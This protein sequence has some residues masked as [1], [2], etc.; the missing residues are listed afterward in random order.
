MESMS[1]PV[2]VEAARGLPSLYQFSVDFSS[3]HAL[4][5]Q[6]L[7]QNL[8]EQILSLP[9]PSTV[10][11]DTRNEDSDAHD[12]DNRLDDVSPSESPNA[13]DPPESSEIE[14]RQ[15][16]SEDSAV[17]HDDDQAIT[18]D[19]LQAAELPAQPANVALPTTQDE[20]PRERGISD[21][22]FEQHADES[23]QR[24]RLAFAANGETSEEQLTNA[25][26]ADQDAELLAASPLVDGN[27]EKQLT[28]AQQELPTNP[29]L[30]VEQHEAPLAQDTPNG[31]P[32]LDAGQVAIESTDLA[33]EQSSGR[34]T[35]ALSSEQ[36]LSA[37]D[38]Q[39]QSDEQAVPNK[40]PR[41]QRGQRREKWYESEAGA[42]AQTVAL[43]EHS[44]QDSALEVTPQSTSNLVREASQQ[45][46]IAEIPQPAAPVI[47]PA[48]GVT[49]TTID[50]T[51]SIPVGVSGST[52]GDAGGV[53]GQTSVQTDDGLPASAPS[54]ESMN[55][56][57]RNSRSDAQSTST[58]SQRTADLTQAERVRLV[59]RVSRS[60]ARL[61]PTGGSINLKLHPP[62]LGSLNVQ[63]RLEG[64]TMTAKLTTESVAAR[65]VI[66]ESLPVLR[67][68]LAEQGFEISQFQVDVAENHADAGN[69][70]GNQLNQSGDGAGQSYRQAV[71]QRRLASQQRQ[72]QASP[73]AVSALPARELGWQS[74]AGIDLHA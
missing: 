21:A 60:F 41:V 70:S 57:N 5:G 31:E 62:Q 59:Q 18:A 24:E 30:P 4:N 67:G 56:A 7:N 37:A 3:P 34:D 72:R 68:R 20:Q 71:D 15:S 6:S 32:A 29:D 53:S 35:D 49:A 58:N 26:H 39:S 27:D 55:A 22:A 51:A 11:L 8:F 23:S 36:V 65:D 61:S 47:Q 50:A 17:D 40:D 16:E 74:L 2:G 43:E 46:P 9:A 25:P 33:I 73:E 52:A 64:R 1:H 45:V 19:A 54:S 13:D 42:T 38:Q 63:V 10:K 28:A 48:V 14:D 66:L 12:A 44:A 69:T